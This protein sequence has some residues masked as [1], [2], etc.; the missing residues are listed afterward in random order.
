MARALTAGMQAVLRD[1][2]VKPVWLVKLE[3]VS[4]TI[5]LS[6]KR[7]DIVWN[8][9]TWLGN[10]MLAG[11]EGMSDV[12]DHTSTELTVA[13]N[14]LDSGLMSL[15][16]GSTA[17]SKVCEVYFGL[18]N[19]S[20]ALIVDP[21]KIYTGKFDSA[22]IQESAGSAEI[23]LRYENDLLKSNR[24]NIL[25]FT[26]QSQKALFPTDR[27][28]EYASQAADWKG[29]WGQAK[30]PKAMQKKKRNSTK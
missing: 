9:V 17:Q 23:T 2:V 30:S 27:G 13:L 12:K 16:L 20:D 28:F 6:S 26:D 24:N 19:T 8:A 1:M 15:V 5:Y 4:T 14:A 18:L 11:L 10:G 29:F 25:R 7:S 22:E 21:Y 3:F